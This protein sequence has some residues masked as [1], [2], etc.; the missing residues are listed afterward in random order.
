MDRTYTDVCQLEMADN[1]LGENNKRLLLDDQ[2]AFNRPIA[3][4]PAPW[5][6][7]IER[8]SYDGGKTY[9]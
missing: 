7:V 9:M 6:D 5:M 4:A 3:S 1:F 2:D 8:I